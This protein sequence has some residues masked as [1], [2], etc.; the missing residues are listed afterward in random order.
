MQNAK[1][2]VRLREG[3]SDTPPIRHLTLNKIYP[4]E[5]LI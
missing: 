2:R 4:T 1:W 5:I 3:R